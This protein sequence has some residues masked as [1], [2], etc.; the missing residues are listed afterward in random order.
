MSRKTKSV[1]LE[2][3][4]YRQRRFAD[5]AR[6]LPLFGAALF[7]IPLLWSLTDDKVTLT[8]YVMS[9][10]FLSWVGLI[11]ISAFVSSKLPKDMPDAAPAKDE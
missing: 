5:G 4:A 3:R 7:F 6:M 2:R 11:I 1:F 10:V 8:S 9:F